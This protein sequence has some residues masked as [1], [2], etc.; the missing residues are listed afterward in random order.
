LLHA[1]SALQVAAA[2]MLHENAPH[3]LGG[4]REEVRAIL[5]LHPPA[6]HQPDVRFVTRAVV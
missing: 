6:I 3:Q 4:H 5:P 2:R 1:C